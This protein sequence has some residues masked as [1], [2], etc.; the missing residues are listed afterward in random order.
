MDV[1]RKVWAAAC[2]TLLAGSCWSQPRDLTPITEQQLNSIRS[3]LVVK[4]D[5]PAIAQAVAEAS[6]TI[7]EF[8]KINSCLPGYNGSSLNRYAAPGMTY[9]RHGY[10][11]GPVA[12]IPRHPKS[13][14]V[15]VLRVHGWSMPAKN[16]LRFEVVYVSDETGQS[17]KATHEVVR[18]PGGEW[19]FAR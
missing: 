10:I 9:P 16:A 5:Q 12:A 11:G 18:Q 17:S 1:T 6:A 15:T 7:A 13:A 2:A 14:C 4:T 19:L 8:L 3:A